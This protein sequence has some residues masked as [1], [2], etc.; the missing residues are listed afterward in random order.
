M[1]LG[2]KPA[3]LTVVPVVG[4][5]A[6]VLAG[7]LLVLVR[8][9]TAALAVRA[10]L[11]RS[12]LFL[13]T[14]IL[15]ETE[16]SSL[17][18]R[19][20]MDFFPLTIIVLFLFFLVLVVFIFILLFA[21]VHLLVLLAVEHFLHV[22]VLERALVRAISPMD[23]QI[24]WRHVRVDTQELI[25]RLHPQNVGIGCDNLQPPIKHYPTA[26]EILQS[27]IIWI[28]MRNNWKLWMVGQQLVS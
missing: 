11:L 3:A 12:A 5:S 4:L 24:R 14:S 25:H 19:W 26:L 1:L 23:L 6:L 10:L 17:L 22:H 7:G 2:T 8:A 18:G 28:K 9:A 27:K 21:L 16:H 13:L 20:L 15:L